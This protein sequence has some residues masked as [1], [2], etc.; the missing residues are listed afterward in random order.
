MPPEHTPGG[1]SRIIGFLVIG[2][3]LLCL[4]VLVLRYFGV[5]FMTA[6]NSVWL[7]TGWIPAIAGAV[8]AV[9]AIPAMFRNPESR[10]RLP[11][12]LVMKAI[13]LLFMVFLTAFALNGAIKISLPMLLASLSRQEVV[14]SYIV[15][16]PKELGGRR[17][18]CRNA[19][20]TDLPVFAFA[21]LCSVPDPIRNTLSKGDTINVHGTGNQHGVFY[22]GFSKG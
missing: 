4:P 16:D 10:Q 5:Y 21:N 18:V 22:T 3:W 2:S 6:P 9:A 13:L 11:K 8:L 19:V 20:E 7:Q 17:E 12:S 14:H 15:T 1:I